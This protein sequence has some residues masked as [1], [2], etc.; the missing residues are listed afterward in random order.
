MKKSNKLNQAKKIIE[1]DAT[2]EILG[3]LATKIS[4]LLQGKDQ[5]TYKPNVVIGNKVVVSNVS[6][7]QFTGRKLKQKIYY[8]HS[9]YIGNLKSET[10]GEKFSRT[11]EEVLRLAVKGMLPK[12]KL[13]AIFLNNLMIQK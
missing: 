4:T 13:Q 5:P 10:L 11:P 7:I 9:G 6:K 2:G 1:I 12:N 3:R 8:R